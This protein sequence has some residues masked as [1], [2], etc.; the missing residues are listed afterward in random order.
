MN[1]PQQVNQVSMTHYKPPMRRRVFNAFLKR[2][3]DVFVSVMVL[4]LAAPLL[5]IIALLV[6]LDGGSVI[7]KH[8]RVGKDIRPFGCLKFR[9]MVVDA[10][11]R[12][13]TYLASNP[14]ERQQW[15][16]YQK[17]SNDP[18]VTPVGRFLRASSLDEL[19]QIFNV[20]RGE[21]SLVGPRPVTNAELSHYNQHISAYAS[22]LPGI[23]GLWQVSGRSNLSYERRV[24]LDCDYVAN[25]SIYLDV[26]LLLRT[27]GVVMTGK[28]AR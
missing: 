1:Q 28:G 2:C 13:E 12:L 8:T 25:H 15:E 18:R 27:V 6:S 26:K 17:L 16:R 19:P 4:I 11:Q 9:T 3:F 10:E 20:L 14:A 22:V 24:E 21:M 5:A 23:T 7:F